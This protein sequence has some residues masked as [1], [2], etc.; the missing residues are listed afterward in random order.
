MTDT[1]LVAGSAVILTGDSLR[2]ALDATLIAV[3]ARQLSGLSVDGYRRLAQALHTAMATNGRSDVPEPP[4]VTPSLAPTVPVEEAAAMLGLSR[5]QTRR[6]APLLGGRIIAGR[7]LLDEMC[8]E[9]HLRGKV[10]GEKG[11]G[12]DDR[13]HERP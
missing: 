12:P 2:V 13:R 11:I 3:R 5:R 1:P 4:P 7:W 6:L 10:N 8:I 9:E